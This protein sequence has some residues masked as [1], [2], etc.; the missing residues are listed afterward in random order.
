[1]IFRGGEEEGSRGYGEFEGGAGVGVDWR[2][3]NS[4]WDAYTGQGDIYGTNLVSTTVLDFYFRDI[5][6]SGVHEDTLGT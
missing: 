6:N 3:N 1:M 4:L 5:V 2:G